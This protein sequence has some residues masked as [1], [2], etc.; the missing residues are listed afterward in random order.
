MRRTLSLIADTALALAV[1]AALA[2]AAVH[3]ATPCAAG[4]LC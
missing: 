3:F 2:L 4:A 1:G